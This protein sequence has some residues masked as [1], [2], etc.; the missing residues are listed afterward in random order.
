MIASNMMGFE[1]N[2]I[3]GYVKVL[4]DNSLNTAT[5]ITLGA[6][7]LTRGILAEND[8]VLRKDNVYG[9]WVEDTMRPWGRIWQSNGA[10]AN[11]PRN[12]TISLNKWHYLVITANASTLKVSMFIDKELNAQVDYDG[13][14]QI[15]TTDLF[16]SSYKGSAAFWNGLIAM[17][18]IHDRA[19]S[20]DEVCE[21]YYRSPIYRMLRGLPKSFI[22][23]QVPWKQT[24][25]GIYVS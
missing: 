12:R 6:W 15:D 19:W 20:P 17:P 11:L 22:Y 16:V 21:S 9:M 24:Q 18:H 4:N 14:I 3:T 13:T 2:G 8:H 23:V 5:E 7:V 10:G 25:G 1:F